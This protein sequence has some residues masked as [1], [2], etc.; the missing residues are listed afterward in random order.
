MFMK[1][2]LLIKVS[3]THISFYMRE[4]KPLPFQKKN[5]LKHQP[6]VYKSAVIC[7]AVG[8]FPLRKEAA[9]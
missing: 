4:A 9:V 2:F 1:L 5:Q 3:E 8:W 6:D 7:W